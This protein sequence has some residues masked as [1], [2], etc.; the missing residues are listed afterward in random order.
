EHVG[1]LDRVFETAIR[2][3]A[4]ELAVV[5]VEFAVFGTALGEYPGRITHH[6]VFLSRAERAVES[7]GGDR[8][9]AR[10]RKDDVHLFDVFVGDIGGIEEGRPGAARAAV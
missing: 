2:D 3:V 8:R 4:G 5:L 10:P 7:R 6:D 9:R 1:V